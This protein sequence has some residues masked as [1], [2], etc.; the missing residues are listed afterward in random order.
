[1]TEATSF[2]VKLPSRR[3]IAT[4]LCTLVGIGASVLVLVALDAV[5][6]ELETE[7]HE[8]LVVC[9]RGEEVDIGGGWRR[10]LGDF[11]ECSV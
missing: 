5:D 1:M 7:Q 3:E 6:A 10:G 9:R 11:F 2:R 4:A 8:E